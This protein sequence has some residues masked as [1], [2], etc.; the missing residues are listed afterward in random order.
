MVMVLIALFTLSAVP[1]SAYDVEEGG[2]WW[3]YP[4]SVTGKVAKV[5][6]FDLNERVDMCMLAA[7]SLVYSQVDSVSFYGH[8]PR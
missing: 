7:D 3:S 6:K 5:N 8:D 4:K 2:V 1:A